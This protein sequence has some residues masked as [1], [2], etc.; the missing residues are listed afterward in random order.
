MHT[1]PAFFLTLCLAVL[2][3]SLVHAAINPDYGQTSPSCTLLRERA[4]TKLTLTQFL[5]SVRTNREMHIP[6][7]TRVTVESGLHATLAHGLVVNGEL[8]FD[9]GLPIHL[10]LPYLVVRG[11]MSAGTAANPYRGN[12]TIELY[13]YG[14]DLVVTNLS[15]LS[16]FQTLLKFGRKAFAVYGGRVQF[17]AHVAPPVSTTLKRTAAPGATRIHVRHDVS[18]AWA[19]GDTIAIAPTARNSNDVSTTATITRIRRR[20]D[21]SCL[22]FIDRPVQQFHTVRNVQLTDGSKRNIEM[23]PAV[24]KLNRNIQIRGMPLS[25]NLD[26]WVYSDSAEPFGGHFIIAHSA[27][28]NVVHGVEFV[29]MGQ[30]GILG[31]YPLHFHFGA[32]ASGSEL[33]YNS[34]HH[35]KQRC[36]VVHAT[37]NLRVH[38]NVAFKTRGHCFMT[39]DGIETGNQFI[40][41]VGMSTLTSIKNIAIGPRDVMSDNKPATFWITN[42]ANDFVNNVA[43]ASEG[44]GFWYELHPMLRGHS[45]DMQLPGWRTVNMQKTNF[46]KFVGN[47]AYVAPAGL[48][49]YAPG[50]HP[51]ETA[52]LENF[53][54]WTVASGWVSLTGSNQKM[55]DSVLVDVTTNGFVSR[56]VEGFTL[57][58]VVIVGERYNNGWTCNRGYRTTG[59]HFENDIFEN[60][61]YHGLRGIFVR[62]VHFQE[63]E[64]E[65]NCKSNIAINIRV[66]SETGWFPSASS[67]GSVTKSDVDQLFN[68]EYTV[69]KHRMVG[70]HV[71][72]AGHPEV[73]GKGYMIS[74]PFVGEDV[75]AKSCRPAGENLTNLIFCKR[76]CWRH[77]SIAWNDPPGH[78]NTNIRFIW[79]DGDNGFFDEIPIP[80]DKFIGE[81]VTRL[82]SRIYPAGIYHVKLLDQNNN[83]IPDE[84]YNIWNIYMIRPDERLAEHICPN[85]AHFF[86][87][88]IEVPEAI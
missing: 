85:D 71:D 60:R 37:H 65:R 86:V 26:A 19:P 36:L 49:T 47:T 55:V 23:S 42:P 74:A 83:P 82:V 14:A 70:F 32:D 10:S 33:A 1:Y 13:D 20:R 40:E 80:I 73:R 24:I 56:N 50:C 81:K 35:S 11:Y 17:Y 43:A 68:V 61:W 77:V 59:L 53:F 63:F 75:L 2:P 48:K 31:R 3:V 78:S 34:I 12:L 69:S 7:G 4:L 79:E 44:S 15:P 21:G 58:N 52:I 28:A 67:F 9:D 22:V 8:T 84:D 72:N 51:P 38:H 62:N 16:K 45:R 25:Q 46:G 66:T 6:C 88:G 30:P 64:R 5:S 18:A 39:E 27:E 57:E 41:N 29:A 54:A 76:Q 87:H